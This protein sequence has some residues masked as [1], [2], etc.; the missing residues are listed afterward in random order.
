M[1][2]KENLEENKKDCACKGEGEKC[3][4]EEN[5]GEHEHLRGEIREKGH[6]HGE[7][8]GCEKHK[9]HKQGE[10]CG[11][12]DHDHEHR[13]DHE[14]CHDHEHGH[15]HGHEHEHDHEHDHDHEHE[16]HD[17]DRHDHDDHEHDHEDHD[18]EHEHNHSPISVSTHETSVIGSYKLS[19]P[20]SFEEAG[21]VLDE[22]M[23]ALAAD[24]VSSGGII[25]HIKANLIQQGPCM[26]V[27]IT[28]DE[29]NKL[30]YEAQSCNA[31]GVAI[32]FL[33]S[34]QRLMELMETHFGEFE[35]AN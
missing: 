20:G 25:G 2:N 32:V 15:E 21:A 12:K 22:R 3:K 17:H 11:C 5:G 14:H 24:V 26:M 7:D 31:D 9:E 13:H 33:I 6:K 29:S 34:P 28:E 8:C 10:A 27:S 1:D 16:A 19:I 35:R 23:K 4:C 30:Y 18:H